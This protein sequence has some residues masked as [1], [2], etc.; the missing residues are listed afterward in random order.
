MVPVCVVPMHS[1]LTLAMLSQ[2]AVFAVHAMFSLAFPVPFPLPSL[3]QK[4]TVV[5][6]GRAFERRPFKRRLVMH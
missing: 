4:A 3:G 2:F 6:V 5:G 1:V